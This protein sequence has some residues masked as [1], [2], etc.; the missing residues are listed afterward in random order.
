MKGNSNG[1]EERASEQHIRIR[2]RTRA[3]MSEQRQVEPGATRVV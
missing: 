1:N 3:S 2:D